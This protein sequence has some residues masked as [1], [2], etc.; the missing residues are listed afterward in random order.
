MY[1]EEKKTESTS[2]YYC[3]YLT[4]HKIK[5]KN[6]WKTVQEDNLSMASDHNC[7][8]VILSKYCC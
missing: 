1:T 3:C 7:Q 2:Y 5:G 8:N 6:I 4:I